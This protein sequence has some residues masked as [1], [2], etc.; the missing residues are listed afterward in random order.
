VTPSV[1]SASGG[2]AY[3]ASM[4][5]LLVAALLGGALLANAGFAA[6]ANCQGFSATMVGTKHNDHIRGT[7]GRDII[8]G[9]G[10][11]DTISSLGGDD[12]ICGNGGNDKLLAGPGVDKLDGG[13]GRN[14]LK[15]GADA[16]SLFGGPSVDSFW[17]GSGNDVVS[18]GGTGGHE[19]VHYENSPGPMNID[20]ASGEA[21]GFGTDLL[22][23]VLDV[24]GSMFGDVVKGNDDDNVL[25]LGKGNDTGVGRGGSD[26][27][28][29]G[30][31]AD[32]LDG[33]AGANMNDGGDGNDHC[34][35][36][37]PVSGALHCESP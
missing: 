1:D 16:D 24:V 29:G 35:K 27:I 6:A 34:V 5:T 4:R 19:W 3:A 23:A 2:R 30:P 17:P 12:R 26:T 36:P 10:G 20:L 33:G 18:G 11:N 7:S 13:T 9:L 31:G 25:E 8:V 22:F 15:G 32:D 21:N 37:D 28:F 14:V